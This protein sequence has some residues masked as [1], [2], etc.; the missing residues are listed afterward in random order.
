MAMAATSVRLE[1]SCLGNASAV[2]S[3][4]LDR[5]KIFLQSVEYWEA[6]CFEEKARNAVRNDPRD[7]WSALHS[8]VTART[9]LDAL[10][11]IMCLKGFGSSTN[12][13]TMAYDYPAQP[14]TSFGLLQSLEKL[15]NY[16]V[17][18]FGFL[19]CLFPS[20]PGG[21]VRHRPGAG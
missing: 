5:V 6:D 12:Q 13:E 15:S 10:L 2:E 20:G 7:M 16:R 4:A 11:S 1:T 14:D 17:S 8:A 18:L 3:H 19:V 21:Q 9:D